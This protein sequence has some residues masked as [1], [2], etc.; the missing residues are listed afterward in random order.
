MFNGSI[1][2]PWS[3]TTYDV[4]THGETHTVERTHFIVRDDGGDTFNVRIEVL[5]CHLIVEV[6]DVRDTVGDDNVVSGVFQD[7]EYD[8]HMKQVLDAITFA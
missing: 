3:V 5:E 8:G 4:T 1:T 2:E 6:R 7:D